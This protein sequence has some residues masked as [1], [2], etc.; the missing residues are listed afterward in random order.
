MTHVE[1]VVA[2][3]GCKAEEVDFLDEYVRVTGQTVGDLYR[4]DFPRVYGEAYAA[5]KECGPLYA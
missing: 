4:E 2:A 3:T 5:F 1:L